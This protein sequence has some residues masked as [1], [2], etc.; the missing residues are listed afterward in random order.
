[1]TEELFIDTLYGFVVTRGGFDWTSRLG[2]VVLVRSHEKI[3]VE[4]GG[5]TICEQAGEETGSCSRTSCT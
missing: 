3:A 1:M 4:V 2:K 5:R